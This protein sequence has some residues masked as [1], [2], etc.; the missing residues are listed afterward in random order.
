MK[1][2]IELRDLDKIITEAVETALTDKQAKLVEWKYFTLAE[3]SELLQIKT[4]TLLDKRQPYLNE[5]EYSQSGKLFWFTKDSVMKYIDN[6]QIKK[7]RR[8]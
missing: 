6:R 1:V 2:E 7:Y 5:L 3:A 8:R 4:T